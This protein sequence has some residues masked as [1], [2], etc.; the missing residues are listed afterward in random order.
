MHIDAIQDG[1]ALFLI[2]HRV[3]FWAKLCRRNVSPNTITDSQYLPGIRTVLVVSTLQYF[4]RTRS[5][6]TEHLSSLALFKENCIFC[7]N[8]EVKMYGNDKITCFWQYVSKLCHDKL[9]ES[10]EHRI[11]KMLDMTGFVYVK[12]CKA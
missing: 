11:K 3:N 6:A 7:S 4:E 1:T 5:H 12:V 9:Y 8:T 2:A 10:H